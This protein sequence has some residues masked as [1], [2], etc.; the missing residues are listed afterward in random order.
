MCARIAVD[1]R[2]D[3]DRLDILRDAVGNA[4]LDAAESLSEPDPEGWL[5]L[6][7]RLD[8][9]DEAPLTMLRAGPWVEVLG[10]PEIRA[11]VAATARA[12][13]ERYAG[14]VDLSL[15]GRR[16]RLEHGGPSGG[17]TESHADRSASRARWS[18]SRTMADGSRYIAD[19]SARLAI[20]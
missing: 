9:P 18:S 1:V 4:A 16:Q 15:G 3:P 19:T 11:R 5:R 12:I 7:L 20:T 2:V 8:W 17:G 6:R 14:D 10:P 13:A